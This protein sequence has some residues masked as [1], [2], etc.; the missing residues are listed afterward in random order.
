MT[1]LTHNPP[2]FLGAA[3]FIVPLCH[4][5]GLAT[6]LGYLITGIIIG[7]NLLNLAGNAETVLHFAEFGVVMLFLIG[8]ELRAITFMGIKTLHFC[9]RWLAS[10]SHRSL[11]YGCR[12]VMRI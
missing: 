9:F 2:F 11:V 4:R 8:L 1:L 5:F 7:P 6:V 12:F 10:H 3:L